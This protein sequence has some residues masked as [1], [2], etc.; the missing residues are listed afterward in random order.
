MSR[1][2]NLLNILVLLVIVA[3]IPLTVFI[4]QKQQEVR[5]RAST[6]AVSLFVVPNTVITGQSI[7]IVASGPS[8]CAKGLRDP[9]SS[10]PNGFSNCNF[11]SSCD[12]S[13]IS[14]EGTWE[15]AAGQPGS[16]MIG[17][18][19]DTCA[20]SLVNLTVEAP[21]ETVVTTPTPTRVPS[22]VPSPTSSR[23]PTSQ[24]TAIPTASIAISA[25]P[26]TTISPIP[27]TADQQQ[28]PTPSGQTLITGDINQDGRLDIQDYME[29]INCFGERMNSSGCRYRTQA[30][31]THDGEVN[32]DDLRWLFD[33]FQTLHGD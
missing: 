30:D 4:A 16:Y 8:N 13:N 5:Q 24:P 20:A 28:T 33:S 26:S 21:A 18:A 9:Y 3:A 27:S 6:T 15:C 19:S 22:T 10:P 32:L 17:V 14:C 1:F 7:S 29:F 11:S 2:S 25:I 31:I 23:A 12:A